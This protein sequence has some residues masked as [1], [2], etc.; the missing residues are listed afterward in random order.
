M[1]NSK[2][3]KKIKTALEYSGF[4]A[5]KITQ[6]TAGSYNTVFEVELD[7]GQ[8][9]VV[10]IFRSKR[11]PED[12]KLEWISNK[13]TEFQIPTAKILYSSRD[14]K[15]FPKGFMVQEFIDGEIVQNVAGK[16]ITYADYYSQLGLLMSHVHKIQLPQF[17]YIGHGTGNHASLLNYID[18][19]IDMFFG[20]IEPIMDKIALDIEVF[21]EKIFEGLEAISQLSHV[22]THNDLS[23]NNVMLDSKG[24][25]VLIDWDNAV[26]HVWINDFGVMTY[27][28]RYRHQNESEREEYI[29]LF[30]ASYKADMSHSEIR[31][32][33]KILHLIQALNLLGYYYFDDKDMKSFD[34]TLKY[35]NELKLELL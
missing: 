15:Y 16:K 9:V 29:R 5:T 21:K 31:K 12:G 13:L 18:R 10:R 1:L 27:W 8:R 6:L 32:L 2:M 19:D 35:F 17:G 7:N 4:I 28:M 26:S 11:W 24:E 23:P 34:R 20:R 30:L 3:D 14:D 25:L 33:E 22:L